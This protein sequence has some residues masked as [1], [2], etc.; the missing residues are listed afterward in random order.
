MKGNRLSMFILEKNGNHLKSSIISNQS[1]III[2]PGMS[3]KQYMRESNDWRDEK[4]VWKTCDTQ[5]DAAVN[6]TRKEKRKERIKSECVKI[7]Y[8]KKKE[9]CQSIELEKSFSDFWL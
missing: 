5:Q 1:Y 6:I 9:G 8:Q 7:I 3:L 2:S 4:C